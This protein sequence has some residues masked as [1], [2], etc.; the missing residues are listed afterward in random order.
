MLNLQTFHTGLQ[1][2]QILETEATLG[3][4]RLYIGASDIAQCP[5]KVVKGKTNPQPHT[6][7]SLIRFKRGH[8]A[9]DIISEALHA[10]QHERQMAL[11]YVASYCPLCHWYG[12]NT[13]H[14]PKCSTQLSSLPLTAHLDFVFPDN[15]ILEV[16]TTSLPAIQKSWEMQLQTQMY[17]YKEIQGTSPRGYILTMDI[18]EGTLNLTEPYTLNE[19][20]AD[21]IIGRAINLW[22]SLRSEASQPE[23]EPSALCCVCEYLSDCPAFEGNTLPEEVT[24]LIA[25]YHS[26]GMVEKEAAKDKSRLRT[27]IL[28]ALSPGKY[29]AGDFRISL[30]QRSRTSTDNKAIAFLLKELG[31]DISKYQSKSTYPV[32]DIKHI[33]AK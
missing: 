7:Q 20:A 13:R 26:A 22:E 14:C 24:P 23:T 25:E 17:L 6:L 18:A 21:E 33:S 28:G 9:E 27:A 11:E 8:I 3:D 19:A 30:S 1:T 12:Q 5:R 10:F 16:K 2:A 31:Q 29:Q 32:L 15:T 4:R